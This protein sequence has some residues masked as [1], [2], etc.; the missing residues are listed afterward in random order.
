[1]AV[2][3]T[4]ELFVKK[5]FKMQSA[6]GTIVAH[7]SDTILGVWIG[8]KG[9]IEGQAGVYLDR[10]SKTPAIVLYPPA[11]YRSPSSALPFAFS[12]AGLQVPLPDGGVVILSL[13]ELAG[14]AK[15]LRTSL[16]SQKEAEIATPAHEGCQ[17]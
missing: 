2:E 7:V 14:L 15:S 5:H 9:G 13:A 4:D 1:M 3:E 8:P 16:D 11:G 12:A 10:K 6:L 17:E